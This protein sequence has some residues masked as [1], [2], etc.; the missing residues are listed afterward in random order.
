M[1]PPKTGVLSARE[2]VHGPANPDAEQQKQQERPR[3][4]LHALHRAAP[5]QEAERHGYQQREQQHRLQVA[6]MKFHRG[7]RLPAAC[8]FVR[9]QRGQ[10]VE[11]A[12]SGQKT[13]S[14]IAISVGNIR[15]ANLD[16][17]RQPVETAGAQIGEVA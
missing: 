10:Q 17:F 14:I 6:Q 1:P 16:I 8:G 9:V 2:R 11:H 3:D 4:V 7:L 5:A 12:G 15:S 13:R